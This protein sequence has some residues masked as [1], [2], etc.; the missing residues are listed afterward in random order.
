V[1]CYGKQDS[2]LRSAYQIINNSSKTQLENLFERECGSAFSHQVAEAIVEWRGTFVSRR[3]IRSTLEL[4]H[5]IDS[6]I[7]LAKTGAAPS[8]VV[9]VVSRYRVTCPC[10]AV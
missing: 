3:A 8:L 2:S 7:S 4:R 9:G 10:A 1:L 5:I 6:A